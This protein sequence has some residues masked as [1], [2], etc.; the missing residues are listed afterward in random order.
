MVEQ[1]QNG[2][3]ERRHWRMAGI[4]TAGCA[5]VASGC[6]RGAAPGSG[7]SPVLSTVPLGRGQKPDRGASQELKGRRARA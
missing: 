2:G 1:E 5:P 4:K 6:G 7:Y 3:E